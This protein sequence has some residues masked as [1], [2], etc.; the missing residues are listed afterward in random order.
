[1]KYS[2]PFGLIAVLLSTAIVCIL[3][4]YYL[5]TPRIYGW[6][7]Y[8]PVLLLAFLGAWYVLAGVF[9]ERREKAAR[10][11]ADKKAGNVYALASPALLLSLGNVTEHSAGLAA[12]VAVSL[13]TVV[14]LVVAV[15]LAFGGQR[16]RTSAINEGVA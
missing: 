4:D 16:E 1:M 8:G 15:C 12:F 2:P 7:T 9:N 3:V 13:L 14:C 5:I 11:E 6:I 10:K